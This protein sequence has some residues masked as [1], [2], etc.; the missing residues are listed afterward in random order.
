M[1]SILAPTNKSS[2]ASE[3]RDDGE[4]PYAKPCT[5]LQTSG[6]SCEFPEERIMQFSRLR[7][8]QMNYTSS[9]RNYLRGSWSPNSVIQCNERAHVAN[10]WSSL[11]N[12]IGKWGTDQRR[13]GRERKCGSFTL[14][15]SA[16]WAISNQPKESQ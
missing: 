14:F 7:L 1:H 16:Y 8:P 13:K 6:A 10:N 4:T 3:S 5:S 9:Y 2:S 11:D 15:S 12:E